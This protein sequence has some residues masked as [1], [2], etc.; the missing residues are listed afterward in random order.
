MNLQFTLT[1]GW[2][3]GE[4]FYYLKR[5]AFLPFI[6]ELWI[7]FIYIS[8]IHNRDILYVFRAKQLISI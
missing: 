2:V 1:K 4:M 5:I 6:T 3:W 8:F 7:I